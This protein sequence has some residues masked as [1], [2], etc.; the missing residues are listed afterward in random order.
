MVQGQK[1][2]NGNPLIIS[3]S[4]SSQLSKTTQQNGVHDEGM[5]TG[6]Y[7]W[8]NYIMKGVSDLVCNSL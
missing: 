4:Q 6:T 1:Q 3:M 5:D 2:V 7:S 8:V